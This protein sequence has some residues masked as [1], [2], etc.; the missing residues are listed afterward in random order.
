MSHKDAYVISHKIA[1]MY[2]LAHYDVMSH[3]DAYVISR[4]VP[5]IVNSHNLMA[6]RMSSLT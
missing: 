3:K 1:Y 5:C 4:Q 6:R 2:K